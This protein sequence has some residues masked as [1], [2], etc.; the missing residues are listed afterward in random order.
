MT[1]ASP[2]PFDSLQR[3]CGLLCR[4]KHNH[5]YKRRYFVLTGRT[6]EYW[7]DSETYEKNP[8]K[9][10]GQLDLTLMKVTKS[11]SESTRHGTRFVFQIGPTDAHSRP[12]ET[13]D[14][15]G[16]QVKGRSYTFAHDTVHGK[17][18]WI[19]AMFPGTDVDP[20]YMDA[21]TAFKFAIELTNGVPKAQKKQFLD[22]TRAYEQARRDASFHR[23]YVY[24]CELFADPYLHYCVAPQCESWFALFSTFD[25]RRQGRVRLS[26]L[27]QGLE[28]CCTPDIGLMANSA[29]VFRVMLS[30]QFEAYVEILGNSVV[31]M[32]ERF[33]RLLADY[34]T[35]VK[36][37]KGGNIDA[38]SGVPSLSPF[39]M[40][41]VRQMLLEKHMQEIRNSVSSTRN[42]LTLETHLYKMRH[43]AQELVSRIGRK[44]NSEVLKGTPIR[45]GLKAYVQG[46]RKHIILPSGGILEDMARV[47]DE[48]NAECLRSRFRAGESLE[49]F[50]TRDRLREWLRKEH[51]VLVRLIQK[52]QL[53]RWQKLV[54]R[55]GKFE[56]KVS[57]RLGSQGFGQGL[58][59]FT[60]SRRKKRTHFRRR[61]GDN[62]PGLSKL[63]ARARGANLRRKLRRGELLHTTSAQ[64]G[65]SWYKRIVF[66]LDDSGSMTRQSW[67]NVLCRYMHVMSVTRSKVRT[68][69]K[70]FYKNER[71]ARQ[72]RHKGIRADSQ[73]TDAKVAL[74]DSLVVDA[75]GSAGFPN[76]LITFHSLTEG[77]F[78]SDKL[79]RLREKLGSWNEL[80]STS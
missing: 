45:P 44:L 67:T 6:V 73:Q 11:Y 37:C 3:Q 62:M 65:S 8:E 58:R 38:I 30:V 22:R 9:P 48:F 70:E 17:A 51:E 40:L 50:G 69:A 77:R 18:N 57:G 56:Q 25:M 24:V 55:I 43:V 34:P 72:D 75:D 53:R 35:A 68:E 47:I 79:G 10:R 71:M 7:V 78:F 23:D 41:A 59:S 76:S 29:M 27:R 20:R 28:T 80:M 66:G 52:F 21:C 12:G 42:A 60:E 46:L 13:S 19:H 54:A 2:H 33:K 4:W 14:A 15:A 74:R 63:Q 1:S 32:S 5:F 64:G 49:P 61:S 36:F 39:D 16:S 26:Q 31:S